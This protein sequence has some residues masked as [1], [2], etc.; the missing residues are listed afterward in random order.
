[1]SK[2]W[3]S[4]RGLQR[5][6][7][8]SIAG[9][10]RRTVPGIVAVLLATGTFGAGQIVV[11]QA[12]F[13]VGPTTVDQTFGYTGSTST[14]TVPS[15]V[16]QLSV[17]M[18]GGK[19]GRGGTDSAGPS[20]AGGYQGLVA[21]TM[22]V[23]PGQILTVAVGSGG[24]T[25]AGSTHG[26]NS[27]T[28]YEA[29]A[30]AGGSNPVSG[31]G[32]GNGGVAGFDGGSGN[33]G[34]GGA[35]SVIT[36]GATTIVA[37]GSGGAGGSGQ[38][39]PTIGRAPYSTFL[40]RPDATTGVGQK[41]ITVY[42]VCIPGDRCDGGGGGAG[43]GGIQGG[44]QGSV[45]FGSGSSNEWYGYGGYPGQ[46][47]TG[48]VSGLT[49]SYQ[50]YPNNSGNGSVTISYTGGSPSAPNSVSGMAGN[51]S[52][53]LT[54]TPPTAAG[55]SA[56][57]D[58]VVQY[59]PASSPTSWTTFSDGVSTATSSTVTGLANGT[60]YVFQII[61]VNSVGNGTASDATGTITPSG[62]PA[63]PT[64]GVITAQDGAL[65]VAFTAGT[66]GSAIL[67]YQYQLNGTGPWASTGS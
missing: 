21:G 66:S 63:A 35:A 55:Q 7:G 2:A 33:A 65:S 47:S 44:A 12:A 36:T 11:P 18:T 61:A 32:G 59:A 14:F 23:T 27:P 46:S 13:A 45:Q 16:T 25:G 51:A 9:R 1:M 57:T 56:V 10:P 38:F 53:A 6:A 5:A 28:N 41:G 20:E 49:A 29:G 31:Y 39:A 50:Y 22:A 62:P 67:S 8:I 30:A 4:G 43:G 54:W 3:R 26:Q 52:A 34:G 64:V 17:T 15:G 60:S 40:A 48:S 24:A 42:T 37:G 58:Y 19:G